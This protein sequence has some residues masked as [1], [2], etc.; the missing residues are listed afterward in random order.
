MKVYTINDIKKIINEQGYKIVCLEDKNGSKLISFNQ[1]KVTPIKHLERIVT[2]LKSEVLDDGYYFVCCAYSIVT[3][4]Q[5]DKFAVCKGSAPTASNETSLNIK[6]QI[7]HQSTDVLSYESALKYQQEISDLRVENKILANSN[8][9]L[10]IKVAQLE[11]ELT[12]SEGLA[13]SG[14]S[15]NNLMKF[16]GDALPSVAPILDRYFDIEAKKLDLKQ[17]Q[18]NHVKN[19]SSKEKVFKKIEVGTQEHLNFIENLYNQNKSDLLDLELEKLKEFNPELF[20]NVL[21]NLGLEE[22]QEGQ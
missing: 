18:L 22:E 1:I 4:K 15:T 19:S 14:S 12:E 7:V 5:M 3:A 9:Q 20:K 10:L 6:P 8:E 17:M 16:L 2:R 11:S 13:E 21:E